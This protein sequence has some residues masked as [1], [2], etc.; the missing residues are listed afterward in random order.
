M[1]NHY[2][3]SPT[4]GKLTLGEVSKKIVKYMDDDPDSEYRLIIGTDSQSKNRKGAD[5]VTAILVH[6]VGWGGVYF[7]QRKVI[8]KPL[9]LRNRIYQEA[10]FSLEAAEE[11][12]N[13][14]KY[15]GVSKYKVEIHVDIGASGPTR[16]M[17]A[18]VV[19][20][21][22]GSGYEVKTKPDAYGASKVADRHA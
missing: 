12:L 17:I 6:R 8:S 15:N 3:N 9:A 7:W 16:E 20:M 11:L 5:F 10:A 18:E 4:Y 13:V 1:S 21:I 14:Y 19:G 2:F 22:R